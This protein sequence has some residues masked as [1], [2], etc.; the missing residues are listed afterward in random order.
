MRIMPVYLGP[1]KSH[2]RTKWTAFPHRLGI[3]LGSVGCKVSIVILHY[4]KREGSALSKL[5]SMTIPGTTP[6][7]PQEPDHSQQVKTVGPGTV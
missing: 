1:V 4:P 6:R 7:T 3:C 5:R 2:G